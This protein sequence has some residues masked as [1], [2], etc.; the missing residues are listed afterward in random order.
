MTE[1]L[2]P[3]LS[4]DP[5]EVDFTEVAAST[6]EK[7]SDSDAELLEDCASSM[8]SRFAAGGALLVFFVVPS[9]SVRRIQETQTTL[10]HVLCELTTAAS[11]SR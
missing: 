11:E 9:S 4:T 10:H 3:L 1:S 7:I 8:T 2:H 5:S 6:P